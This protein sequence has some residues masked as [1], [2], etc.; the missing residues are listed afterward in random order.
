MKNLFVNFIFLFGMHTIYFGQN[1]CA[2]EIPE[3]NILYLN[4]NNFIVPIARN[5]SDIL[6]TSEN[7]SISKGTK[8]GRSGF[9]IR[10]TKKGIIDIKLFGINEDGEKINCGN[11]DYIVKPFPSPVILTKTISKLTG[12][13][14]LVGMHESSPLIANFSISDGVILGID[15]GSFEGNRI[16]SDKLKSFRSGSSIRIQLTIKNELTGSME[17]IQGTVDLQ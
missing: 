7:A 14:L 11:F 10:P 16:S 1:T 17:M 6:L 2:I 4:Y 3:Y 13:R 9:F 12:G 8:N 5:F 15:N